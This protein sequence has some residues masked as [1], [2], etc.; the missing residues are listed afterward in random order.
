M[1]RGQAL[2]VLKPAQLFHRRDRDMRIGTD[3]QRAV[4]IE[5]IGQREQTVAEI[6]FGGR[7]QT[8]DSATAR[9]ARGFV[10]GQMRGMHQGPA[11]I[12]FRMI[13]QP[14]D[15][16][17]AARGKAVLHFAGRCPKRS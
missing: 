12:H 17:R 2:A 1:A 14:F 7:T 3:A 9:Q 13:Q 15:R 16:A 6:R 10:A 8:G 5:I 11:P 4:R